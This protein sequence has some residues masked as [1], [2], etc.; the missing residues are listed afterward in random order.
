[1]FRGGVALALLYC[2][3]CADS[4][5]QRVESIAVGRSEMIFPSQLHVDSARA[6]HVLRAVESGKTVR[7]IA[8]EYSLNH[9]LVVTLA[10]EA[11]RNADA[12]SYVDQGLIV[13]PANLWREW[14]LE[15]LERIVR[16]E[17][18]HHALSGYLAGRSVPYW[19]QEGF[20]EWAVGGL[21]CEYEALLRLDL[22]DRGPLEIERTIAGF[23]SGSSSR[24]ETAYSVTFL[25]FLD[26][27]HAVSDG[28]FLA[29]V[30]EFGVSEALQRLWG[31]SIDV[32]E[33]RWW[34]TGLERYRTGAPPAAGCV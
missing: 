7:G 18:N 9:R 11:N 26:E 22:L 3:S 28:R 24:I 27:N 34:T 14:P 2:A 1:M 33:R 8:E 4:A 20:A 16:H 19:L 12:V 13:L 30:K 5:Q 17:V 31:A 6:R 29:A 21:S 25:E 15:T 23:A 10:L 32:L